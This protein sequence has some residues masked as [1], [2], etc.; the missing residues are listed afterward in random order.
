MSKP[1]LITNFTGQAENPHIGSG[2]NVGLDLYTTKNVARLSRKMEKKS[3]TLADTLP[4]YST[5]DNAGFI[6][7][8]LEN[9]KILK[10]I[11]EGANWTLLTGNTGTNG[12]GLVVWQDYLWAFNP[13]G[14]D[15]YGPLS[16]SPS[17]TNG[18]TGFSGGNALINQAS[19]NHIPFPSPIAN[20]YMYITNR[21]Y[22]AQVQVLTFPFNPGGS[23]GTA[24]EVISTK[25]TMQGYYNARCIGFL[26]TSSIAIGV[27][28]RLNNSQADI[29]IWDGVADTSATNVF[30]IPGA[31]GPVVNLL[32]R[33]GVMYATTTNEAGIY[34]VNGSSSQIVDRL[35]LRMTNRSST[36]V[37]Y[38]TRV[39]PTV[40]VGSSDF[41]GPEMLVGICS[42]PSPVTQIT[43]SGLYP[44]GVWGCDVETKNVYTKFPLSHGDINANYNTD[45]EIGFVKVVSNGKVI[46]GW[47]KST[48]Y[49][50]DVLNASDY[51]T[52][53]NTVFV[54]SELYEVGTRIEPETFDRILYNLVEPLQ[55]DEELKFYYRLSQGD[56]YTLFKT[57]NVASLGTNLGG[58]ITPLPFQK[59]KYI[60]IGVKIK[61]G[62]GTPI[63]TPQLVS[64]YLM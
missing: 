31:T 24:W 17:W 46:V 54:E 63:H 55:G 44:Y 29:V 9:G 34:T 14:V 25:F 30:T 50:I 42:Y 36:G 26:P 59:A 51:I 22:V 13:T 35:G 62:T 61:A 58:I 1:I 7:A 4:L 32:T 56:P 8:Q 3:S 23:A 48:T 41:L 37:Q 38:T 11:D 2:V 49:G 64:I 43:G 15:L 28:N 21:E 27:E 5:Q 40:R 12:K 53:E 47:G 45:Y 57:D 33:N 39:Q 52:D 20:A 60:Q 6:Y 10:S 16:G 19:V 18:W